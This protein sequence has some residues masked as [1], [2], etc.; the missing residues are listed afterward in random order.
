[1]IIGS[2]ASTPE[3]YF[4]ARYLYIMGVIDNCYK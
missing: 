2:T 3:V 1:M 4:M